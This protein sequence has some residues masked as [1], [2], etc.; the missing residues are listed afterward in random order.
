MPQKIYLAGPEVFHPDAAALG[1]QKQALCGDYGFDGLFPLDNKIVRQATPAATAM[2]IYVANRG[3]IEAADAVIANLTPFRGPSA[4]PGTVFE[5]GYAARLGRLVLG[6]SNQ[7]GTLLDKTRAADPAASRD[8]ARGI[9]RDCLGLEIEDFGLADNLM[10]ACC[11]EAA[12]APLVIN[13][14]AEDRRLTDLTGFRACLDL[15]RR[16]FVDQAGSSGSAATR[17]SPSIVRP[18]PTKR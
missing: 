15:A 2:A 4:D 14:C 16:W 10:I 1:R 18:R 5:L 13:P 7:E 9:W 8:A 6:Y 3:M 12:G 17:A 11:L